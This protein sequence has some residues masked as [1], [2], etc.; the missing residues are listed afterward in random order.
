M[1]EN[2]DY[3]SWFGCYSSSVDSELI[4]EALHSEKFA[5]YAL[6]CMFNADGIYDFAY[7]EH[8]KMVDHL[9]TDDKFTEE[10]TEYVEIAF[11]YHSARSWR[12][13][14]YDCLQRFFR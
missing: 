2:F 11:G 4:L 6:N 3:I 9:L 13:A 5:P 8:K 10:N 1:I 12:V 7:N 14:F